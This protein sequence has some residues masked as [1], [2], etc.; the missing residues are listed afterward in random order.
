MDLISVIQ[1]ILFVLII[2]LLV[3]PIG[4]YISRVLNP[5]G[6]TFLDF[7]FKPLEKFLYRICKIDPK[8]EYDW[9]QQLRAVLIFSL[10]C[11]AGLFLI[12][13]IQ[14]YL[15]FN[16]QKLPSPPADMNFNITSSFVTTTNWQ[17][18]SGEST[19][20]Y[21]SQ[22]IGLAVQN[23]LGAAAGISVAAT[24]VRGISRHLGTKI[25]NF[26]VDIIRVSL[27]LLLPLSILLAVFYVSQGV[28]QNFKPYVA[29]KCLDSPNQM[30]V[31]G[32]IA[33]Q[34]AI[35]LLGSNGGGFTG[36]NSAHP[37][38]NPNPLTNFIQILSILIIPASMVY[39][40][41]R[42]IKRKKHGW[43]IFFAMLIIFIVSVIVSSFFETKGNTLFSKSKQVEQSINM[44][45]KE[46]RFG[47]F[48]STLYTATT[49][50]V[51]CGA[52]NSSLDSYTPIGGLIPML[53]IQFGEIIF[54]G[55]GSGI[56][57]LIFYVLITIFIS[58]LI[59]GRTPEYIHNKIEIFEIKIC[60][61]ALL[62]FYSVILGST[63]LAIVTHSGLLGIFNKGPH[64]FSEILYA[65]S[66]CM[67]NNGSGF[68]G[69]KVNSWYNY[70]LG[71]A[72]LIG[73]FGIISLVIALAGSLVK[74]RKHPESEKS[75]PVQGITFTFLLIFIIIL[76]GIMTFAPIVVFGPI[77]EEFYMH[78]LHFF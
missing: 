12:L 52:V 14:S 62:I 2:L 58:G 70:S 27:Y 67:G 34:E 74:K 29:A 17:T 65:F 56:Y 20:S 7:L 64:G 51:S 45:G 77:L 39:Y 44:E 16:P 66:S 50:A 19:L 3:K 37:Y 46:Q 41:G 53:N 23:F 28:P 10:I 43:S 33:S 21:F 61:F 24:L 38:E 60:V 9:K 69:L 68:A 49:T 31:Q 73:R 55:V 32:P 78:N 25:G 40:F 72:M 13:Q 15:P 54:G 71:I 76:L 35:K 47:I 8:A 42:E 22:M 30:L 48:G 4:K 1:L 6:R 57:N 36:V 18:Y 75:F 11:F 26:W 5:E 59:V 63:C